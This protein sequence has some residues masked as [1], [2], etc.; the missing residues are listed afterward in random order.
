MTMMMIIVIKVINNV[1]T[2]MR[3]KKNERERHRRTIG[4]GENE[5]VRE[6]ENEMVYK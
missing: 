3:I 1:T 6:G 4:V 5:S 2:A